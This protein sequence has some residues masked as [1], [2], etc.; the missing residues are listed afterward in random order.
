MYGPDKSTTTKSNS[1]Q[2]LY[3]AASKPT[4]APGQPIGFTSFASPNSSGQYTS[5]GGGAPRSAPQ[6]T[7]GQIQRAGVPSTPAP[8]PMDRRHPG[9]GGKVNKGK[10]GHKGKTGIPGIDK[11]LAGDTTYQGQVSSYQKQLQDFI[12]QN[13]SQQGVVGQD[14]A[15]ALSKLQ[16]QRGLDLQNLQNDFAARGLINSG[17]YT[18]ALGQYDTQYQGQ[19]NDLGTGKQRSLDQLL[20][21]LAGYKTENSTSLAAAKQDA[22]RRRAAQYGISA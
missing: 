20:Q 15:T 6:R 16:D 12:N 18:D 3:A 2:G 11:Y 1:P 8:V 9:G 13:N 10:G 17:L 7:P 21:D 4:A 14:F 19:V 5:S 22:I